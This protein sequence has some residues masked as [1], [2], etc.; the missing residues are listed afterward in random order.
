MIM[1]RATGRNGGEYAY[2]FCRGVQDHV[3]D[4]P[5]SNVEQVERAIE[6][7]YK[8][9]R[10]SA[11]FIAAV[12]GGIEAAAADKVRAQR[13]LRQQLENQLRQL[14]VKEENLIDLAADGELPTARIKVKLH[15]LARA[16]TKLTAQLDAVELDLSGG[17]EY[18]NARLDLLTDPQELYRRASD[19]TRRQLNQAFFQRVYVVNDEVIGDELSSPLVEL[20]AAERGWSAL[21]AGQSLD[22]VLERAGGER[23]GRRLETE[24][25]AT[26]EGDL[27]LRTVG[28]LLTALQSRGD[29]S[30]PPLWASCTIP[31]PSWNKGSCRPSEGPF[32][33]KPRDLLRS[34]SG[35]VFWTTNE[36]RSRRW[37]PSSRPMQG[38]D[39]LLM[40]APMRD[41]C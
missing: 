3:C 40:S 36:P 35:E 41:D 37:P 11:E 22:T 13:L 18:I 6:A 17:L 34:R 31:D 15:E 24:E 28:D 29:C 14:A 27:F 32:R 16:R 7:H 38:S 5:Y 2:F 23:A 25:E 26:P 1:M 30:K 12:R 4:A 9:I 20:L 8:T 21:R 39:G 33:A 10:L 19:D